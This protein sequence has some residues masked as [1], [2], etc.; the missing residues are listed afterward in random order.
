MLLNSEIHR[1]K[2]EIAQNKSMRERDRNT[3]LIFFTALC[4]NNAYLL[5]RLKYL[6]IHVDMLEDRSDYGTLD[7]K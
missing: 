4:L 7:E 2:K 1:L 3:K 5:L 6:F